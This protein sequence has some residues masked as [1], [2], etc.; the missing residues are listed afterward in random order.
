MGDLRGLPSVRSTVDH[1][2]GV[3]K[4]GNGRDS[5]RPRRFQLNGRVTPPAPAVTT[6][7]LAPALGA[8]LVGRS[9]VTLAVLVLLVTVVGAVAGWGWAPAGLVAL[10]GLVLVLVWAWYLLRRADA[11]RLT[12]DGYAVRL[13]GGIGVTRAAWSQVE[14]VV[15]TSPGGQPCLLLRL[16]DGG[17]TRLPVAAVVGDPDD[18]ARE[19]RRRVRD[20]HTPDSPSADRSL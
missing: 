9:L 2:A 17:A 19:V 20:A 1:A 11:V 8:R 6:Y 12:A 16:R 18:V 10:V 15:A 14:E 5:R 7:R 13:L 4:A 3:G